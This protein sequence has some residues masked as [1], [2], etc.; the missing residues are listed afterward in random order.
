MTWS[1]QLSKEG[2]LPLREEWVAL[3]SGLGERPERCTKPPR[4]ATEGIE[5][6]VAS[7]SCSHG[8]RAAV[9]KTDSCP[10]QVVAARRIASTVVRERLVAWVL[11]G[12]AAEL[13]R[14]G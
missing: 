2:G 5:R 13:P 11:T 12:P 3:R 6:D 7:Q 10:N 9:E 8:A 4:N 1:G 14:S